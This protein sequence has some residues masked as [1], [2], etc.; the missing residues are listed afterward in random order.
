M[1]HTS[2]ALVVG[3]QPGSV[4]TGITL[5]PDDDPGWNNFSTAGRY[6]YLGDG[7]VLSARHVG[8]EN[9][10]QF[11]TPTGTV[12]AQR[13]PGRYYTDYYGF[14]HDDGKHHYAISNPA[15]V[16]SEAGSPITLSPYTDLQLFR[17]HADREIDL[18]SLKI[19]A[20][21]LPN[22]FNVNNAPQVLAIASGPGRV[23]AE[24]GW[25]VT[26]TSPNLTWTSPPIGSTDHRGYVN[27]FNSTRRWGTNRISDPGDSASLFSNIV[28]NTTGVF[29]LT[30][31]VGAKA[32]DTLSLMTIYDSQNQSGA[33]TQEMQAINGDSGGAL[34]YKRGNQWELA[35]IINAQIVYEDQPELTA[36]YGNATTM[37]D[38]S[39]YNQTYP[40]SIR[41]IMTRLADYSVMGDVNLDG[42]VTGNGTGPAALDDVTAFVA[43]WNYNNGT[44]KGTVTS[45]KHG[46]LNRDGKTDVADF[47]KLRSGL[48]APISSAVVMALFGS[49][50][51]PE[52]STAILASL[53]FGAGLRPRRSTTEGLLGQS[54]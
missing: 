19:A 17:V 26:G 33:T 9:G 46:D 37:A 16:Q 30:L 23:I 36:I 52:P 22:N 27:D 21:P 35:G 4:P 1:C 50:N 41:D 15:T 25:S 11:Q 6:V 31:G 47:L 14:L 12:T 3:N 39:R 2:H 54:G 42:V 5:A 28:S 10:M 43:G 51:V 49:S 29:S 40:K 18:P 48:N 24:S 34:F 45:W 13:I 53:A 20:E 7:W 44:G 38:L 32:R 8:Y